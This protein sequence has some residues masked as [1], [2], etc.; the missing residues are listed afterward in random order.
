MRHNSLSTLLT[1]G[2]AAA[3]LMASGQVLAYGAGDFFT[4]VGVAK[5]EPKSDNGSLAGGAFAVDV[6]DK[7]DFAF[8]LGYRFHDKMGIE[9]LAALPFEH[10]IALNGDNLASTKHL[11]PTLTL[12]YY[13]LGGT[14]ARVQP[15]VGAGINYTFFSDEELAIG[16]LE[17]D[18][19]WGAAAQVGIDL[20]IDENWALN[21]AAWYIDIDTDATVNGAAAGTVEIDPLVVMAGLSYRF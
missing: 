13:P 20:L 21:A 4:R 18:D 2:L 6:Q 1:T 5:V 10:D 3:T 12:Q 8:T 14:D 19:S 15:Y 16:E 9:L 11:P 17:L 7:T